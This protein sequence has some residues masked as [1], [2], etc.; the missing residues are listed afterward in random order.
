MGW[1]LISL[2]MT[3]GIG[4]TWGSLAA[5]AFFLQGWLAAAL[6]EVINYVEHYGLRRE[7]RKDGRY[8]PPGV[9][10][11]WDCDY[12]LSNAIL[13]QLPRHADHHTHASREF[14]QLQLNAQAPILPFGYPLLV[15]VA[16]VPPLWRR[17]IHPHLPESG[18]CEQPA[19]G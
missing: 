18:A 10:H 7:K 16:M 12:W 8:V 9:T 2:I 4:L 11:S 5:A 19:N 1:H 15:L 3:L 14:S 17:I 6:L 13:I